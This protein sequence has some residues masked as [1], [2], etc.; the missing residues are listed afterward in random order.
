MLTALYRITFILS[1]A[2]PLAASDITG[3]VRAD[4]RS[5]GPADRAVVELLQMQLTVAQRQAG[6]DGR[7]EFRN[8]PFGVY[9]LRVRADGYRDEEISINLSRPTSRE[10][11]EVKLNRIEHDP[12][13]ATAVSI[14]ELQIPDKAKGEYKKGTEERQRGKCA[15][16]IPHFEKAIAAFPKYGEAHNELGN[17]LKEE[18]E[19]TRAEAAFKIAIEYTSTVYP[20]INLADLYTSQKRF[21]EARNV[22]LRATAKYPFEGDVYFAMAKLHFDQSQIAEAITAG[23]TAHQKIHRMADVHLLLA[24]AYLSLKDESAVAAQLRLYL[25]ENPK[26]PIADQVRKTL[27]EN[28]STRNR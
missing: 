6:S 5:G 13:L 4:D 15:T 25:E 28:S 16:A 21:A 2:T 26:G 1:L 18:K 19:F 7:F 27:I 23:L 17:C 22:L 9:V 14:T 11:L 8:L 20:A 10:V 3:R 12:V 24:K